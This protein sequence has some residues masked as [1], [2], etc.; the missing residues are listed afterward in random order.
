[1]NIIELQ[2]LKT[3]PDIIHEYSAAIKRNQTPLVIDNGKY[4]IGFNEC[5]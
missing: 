1:M 5:G 4:S 3:V 2:C